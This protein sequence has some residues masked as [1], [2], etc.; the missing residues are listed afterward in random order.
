M[1]FLFTAFSLVIDSWSDC[2]TLLQSCVLSSVVSVLHL[3]TSESVQQEINKI[4]EPNLNLPYSDA[5][6]T[7]TDICL[8][9]NTYNMKKYSQYTKTDNEPNTNCGNVCLHLLNKVS[10][11][12][13]GFILAFQL[14]T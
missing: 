4:T 11:L 14:K 12:T 7:E 2:P 5:K 8:E 10:Y 9:T 1:T 3:L 6:V 13:H